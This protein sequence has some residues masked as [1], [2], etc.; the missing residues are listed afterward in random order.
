MEPLL[1]LILYFFFWVLYYYIESKHDASVI[2][3]KNST[4]DKNLTNEQRKLS[5][6]YRK[7]WHEYDAYE[8]ALVHI[9]VT[10]LA[11][12]LNITPWF[13]LPLLLL[14]LGIRLIVHDT[15]IN[16]F[17]GIDINHIG[18]TDRFDIILR[19]LEQKGISQ[20]AIK[21]GIVMIGVVLCMLFLYI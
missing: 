20:W 10:L 9:V 11:L 19:Y 5:D 6:K 16:K 12:L 4:T 2:L 1:F 18:T 14:S 15:L 21:I 7:D 17:L 8:K 13:I 3:W